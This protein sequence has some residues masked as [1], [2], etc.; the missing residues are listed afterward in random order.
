METDEKMK[1]TL[2]E[3]PDSSLRQKSNERG[4]FGRFKLARALAPVNHF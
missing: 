3:S 2:Y 1:K 4:I